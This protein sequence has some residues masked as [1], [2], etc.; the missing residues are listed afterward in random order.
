MCSGADSFDI[1][2]AACNTDICA[3]VYDGDPADPRAQSKLDFSQTLAFQNF[4][5]DTDP[6]S[7]PSR[8]VLMRNQCK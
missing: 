4:N 3:S 7:H 5:V 1:A 6:I 2:L 8:A